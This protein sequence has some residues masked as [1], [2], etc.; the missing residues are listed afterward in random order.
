MA[1]WDERTLHVD[2]VVCG[3]VLSM[4]TI[5]I[6]TVFTKFGV[7]VYRCG[8]CRLCRRFRC[9]RGFSGG[10]RWIRSLGILGCGRLVGGVV[11]TELKRVNFAIS[12]PNENDSVVN[13]HN[14]CDFNDVGH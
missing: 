8:R 1:V 2:G 13:L 5:M 10:G 9:S 6:V 14:L 4:F 3:V 7:V 12:G 11:M